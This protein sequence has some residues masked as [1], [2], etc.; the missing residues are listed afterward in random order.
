MK[1]LRSLLSVAVIVAFVSPVVTDV[2]TKASSI[3][4][5]PPSI[6]L[7]SPRIQ[8]GSDVANT[9]WTEVQLVPFTKL[10][11]TGQVIDKLYNAM[12]VSSVAS[13]TKEVARVAGWPVLNTNAQNT[14]PMAIDDEYEH[15]RYTTAA[16]MRAPIRVSRSAP[17]LI[18]RAWRPFA[19]LDLNSSK[20]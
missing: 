7:A 8:Y 3:N 6:N 12:S 20:P 16:L 17:Q 9:M 14:L 10:A 19:G 5:S 4:K 18:Q 11:D 13:A 15:T 1:S 2:D